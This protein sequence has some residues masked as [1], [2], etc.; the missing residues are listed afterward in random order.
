MKLF[1][2][3][4]KNPILSPISDRAH[5][6]ESKAVFNPGVAVKDNKIYLLYRALGQIHYSYFGLSILSDP[7]TIEKRLSLPVMEPEEGNKYEQ[8]GVEDARITY[9][10]G[11]YHIVYNAP[12]I[13]RQSKIV[14]LWQH[15]KVPWRIRCMLAQ[16]TDFIHFKRMGNI[17]A[18]IDTK[19]GVLFPEKINGQYTL[20]HRIIPDIWISFSDKL[21]HFS[22]GEILCK[23]RVGK[24]DSER[25][26][27][28]P[29]PIKTLSGWLLIYHGSETID[30]G[31]FIY[32][33]GIMLLDLKD[34][35]KIL[36]RSEEPIFQ[37]EE[38]YERE[39]YV[40]NVVFPTGLI[41]WGDKYWIYY[42]AA[43]QV[44]AAAYID[45]NT[46]LDYLAKAVT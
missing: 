23:P 33:A 4:Q 44:V 28:G 15:M 16:T 13:Y 22:K 24:W 5:W 27:A 29:P 18:N 45:K 34:P 1:I 31:R 46:M 9:L 3:S 41:E 10:E 25:I 40:N 14:P 6:W 21:T 12:S 43:D 39:G 20:L 2:R 37:P 11:K 30:D 36:Y 7:T 19:D 17:I 35:R 8:F 26:G 32:R 38:K 42:G